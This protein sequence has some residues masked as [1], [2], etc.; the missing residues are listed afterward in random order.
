MIPDEKAFPGL[1]VVQAH[2]HDRRPRD[3]ANAVDGVGRKFHARGVGEHPVDLPFPAD[4]ERMVLEG[5][6]DSLPGLQR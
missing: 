3:F 4:L 1:S 6:A 5:L 2:S